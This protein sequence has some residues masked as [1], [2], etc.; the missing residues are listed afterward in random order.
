MSG[1]E[2]SN[3]AEAMQKIFEAMEYLNEEQ[4]GRIM[5]ALNALWGDE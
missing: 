4:I 2:K 1:T 3:E 5:R